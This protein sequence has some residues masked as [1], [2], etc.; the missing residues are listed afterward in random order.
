MFKN[1]SLLKYSKKYSLFSYI[2]INLI[3]CIIFKFMSIW[4][5]T[6][7]STWYGSGESLL[8]RSIFQQLTILVDALINYK[9]LCDFILVNLLFNSNFANLRAL[10]M[11]QLVK[12]PP[13]SSG[14]ARDAGLIPGSEWSPGE[15]NGN[16]F[17]YSCLENS[18]DTRTWWTTVFVITKSWTRLNTY[19]HMHACKSMPTTLSTIFL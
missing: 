18:M 16:P 8:L 5:G 19:A 9:L 15:G 13:A 11:A 6:T 17:Q 14:D 1:T 2:K 10:L 12:N 7:M 4:L 3:S